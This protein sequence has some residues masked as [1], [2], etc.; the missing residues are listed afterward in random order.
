[1]L[2]ISVLGCSRKLAK[3]FEI[4][5]SGI[6]NL[7]FNRRGNSQRWVLRH[8]SH[9]HYNDAIMGAIASQITCPAIVYSIV[10]SDA[11]QR[12]H[13]SPA[14]LALCESPHKWPV[15]RKMFPFNDVIVVFECNIIWKTL[16]RLSNFN[17]E[18]VY[19]FESVIYGTNR[20][21]LLR[22]T[23]S[24]CICTQLSA[25]SMTQTPARCNC[26]IWECDMKV[27]LSFSKQFDVVN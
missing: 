16:L 23:M 5:Y 17:T 12:K 27:V 13:P 15:T 4:C 19:A 14:S 2:N 25:M 1:M 26:V 20:N 22:T 7:N 18:M 21:R 11:D 9:I 24:S 10:Y 6:L 8:T 3:A